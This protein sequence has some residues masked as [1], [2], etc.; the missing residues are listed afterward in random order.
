MREAKAQNRAPD[1]AWAQVLERQMAEAGTALAAGRRATLT[2]LG[3][4]IEAAP[5]SPF[6]RPVLSL[7]GLIEGWL[8][9]MPASAAEDRFVAL[10]AQNR[11][12]DVEAGRS[13]EGPHCSDLI[14]RHRAKDQPAH[15]CSTG[16]QKALL[17]AIILAHARGMA[18]DGLSP[19][20]L[21]DEVAAHLD[22]IRRKALF[23][24]IQEL[25]LQAWMTGTDALLF[26]ALGPSAQYPDI[27]VSARLE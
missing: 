16:E 18:G 9:Q 19:L 25:D 24:V 22:L 13:L 1:P 11:P 23:D 14:V 10:L 21:L 5:E 15:L 7:D 20:L 17:I 4:F 2:R 8:D 6:P 3:G 12:R 27:A 26:D